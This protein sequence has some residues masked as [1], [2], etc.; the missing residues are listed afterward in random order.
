MPEQL[1]ILLI[2][3]DQDDVE[4]LKVALTDNG[5]AFN[6]ETLTRGDLIIERLSKTN[7]VPDIIVMDLNLPKLHG[8]E[9][10]CKIKKDKTF[11]HVPL[12]V[13]TT[14]SSVS[15]REYCL[16]QGANKFFS[17]PATTEGFSLL[18]NSIVEISGKLRGTR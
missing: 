4:F 15:D 14:S 12:M 7:S 3:D 1:H 9:A 2:E 17:K 13:L 5:V 6:M 11:R 18:V 10:L 16:K 8:R